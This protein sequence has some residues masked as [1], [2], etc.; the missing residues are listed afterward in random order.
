[1]LFFITFVV[2]SLSKLLL[3]R[4]RRGEGTVA[5]NT[6]ERPDPG[7]PIRAE[8]RELQTHGAQ[9]VNRIALALS[10]AAMVFGVFWLVLDP[11][12]RRCGWASAA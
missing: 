6:G 12:E 5:M 3:A 9:R 1:V 11:W 8:A 7:G 4:L 2:L 10:L